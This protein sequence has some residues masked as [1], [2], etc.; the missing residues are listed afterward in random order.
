VTEAKFSI[1]TSQ[2]V[3]WDASYTGT[4]TQGHRFFLSQ[5]DSAHADIELTATPGQLSGTKALSAGTYFIS[6]RT[7]LMGPGSY[8]VYGPRVVGEPH[9]TTVNGIHYDFQGVGEFVTVRHPNGFELQTRIAPVATTS[10]PGVDPHSGLAACVSI[11]TA[12][13]ARVGKH[14]VTYQPNISGRPDPKGLQLRVDG[15]LTFLGRLGKNL[16]NGGR[17][18]GISTPGGLLIEFPDQSS[19]TVTP[20]WWADQSRWY[21]DISMFPPPGS[22][23]I[24]GD[25]LPDNWLPLLPDGAPLG[26]RPTSLHDRFITLYQKFADSWRVTD[27]SSLFD[28][29]PGTSTKTYTM[30]S[31]PP[32]HPPCELPFTV[33][34][35]GV[36]RD[37]AEKA[38]QKVMAPTDHKNCV[39]DV[40]AT[41]NTG[42]GRSYV[43]SQGPQGKKTKIAPYEKGT[44][45]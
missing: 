4:A 12:V 34:V 2:T 18:T 44:A 42:F 30:Q 28:Y 37:V 1:A 38:C 41:G 43:I 33:P 21:L 5:T 24:A 17:I 35:K 10:Q 29:A 16:G 26:P 45:Q 32:E 3:N 11:N 8:S 36:N 6:I 22:R 27:D 15:K 20:N 23:G 31:W 7:F 19:V 9:I 14:R 39:F 13:A 40:M 25:I